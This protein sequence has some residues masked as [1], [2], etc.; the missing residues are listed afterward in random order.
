M[1]VC[2]GLLLLVVIP[3]AQ[4]YSH[5]F[6]ICDDDVYGYENYQVK[7][8]LTTHGI[9]WAFECRT[10]ATGIRWPGCRTCSIGRSSGVG[11]AAIT[12]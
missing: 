2:L 9:Q 8:G 4:V 3:Y 11:P 10:S 5:Q 1:L 12:W 6:I 7:D